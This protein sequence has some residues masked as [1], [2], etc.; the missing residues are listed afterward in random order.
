MTTEALRVLLPL[1]AS[2]GLS[3]RTVQF[4]N[5]VFRIIEQAHAETIERARSLVRAGQ[6]A[7]TISYALT[8]PQAIFFDMDATV[9]AEES[10]VEIAKAAGKESEVAALTAKAMAGGMEFAESLRLRLGILKGTPRSAVLGI[11]PHLNPGIRALAEAMTARGVKLFLVSGG[12]MDLAEP[13]A[14]DLGFLD[15]CANRFAWS[16]DV[17][18]GD[19]EGDI[20]GA[21]G[22]RAAVERWC[23]VYQLDPR[24]CIAVG[25]GAN[26]QNMMA[27]CG[28]AVG[29]EPKKALWDK[30]SMCNAVGDHSLLL[31]MLKTHEFTQ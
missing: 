12:F 2:H 14:K 18:A 4:K 7:G 20:V 28:L 26:D 25:D 22:K 24:K 29:F 5:E 1:S 21:E 23:Q 9:I 10:L 3:G 15:V 6:T 8:N 16:G 19:V 27:I 11:K 17:L 30:I 13:V 31:E